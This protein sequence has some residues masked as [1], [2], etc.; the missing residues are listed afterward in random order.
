MVSVTPFGQDGP[1]A[2][3]AASDLTLYAA[4]GGLILTG[5]PDRPPLRVSVP[6]IWTHA[7]TTAAAGA[8]LALH[9][10]AASG[11]GQHVDVA[12][13]EVATL[14]S[15]GQNLAAPARATLAARA[16]GGVN[17]GGLQIRMVWDAK[18]GHVSITHVFGT[19]FG[20]FTRRLMEWVHEEG[21]CDEATRD[22][23]W[24]GYGVALGTGA[25]SAEEYARVQAC[26]NAFTSSKTKAELLAGA[27][28]RRV[29]VAP[30]AD[31]GDVAAQPAVRR[32]GLLAGGRR[33]GARA[34]GPGRGHLGPPV[35]DAAAAARAATGRRRAHRRASPPSRH[36]PDRRAAALPASDDVPAAAAEARAAPLA[37]LKVLDFCWI[38]A[39]PLVTRALADFGATVVRAR[40]VGPPGRRPAGLAPFLDDDAGPETSLVFANANAGKLGITVDLE[41]AEAAPVAARPAWPGRTSSSS[42][43]APGP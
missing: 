3:W 18:D 25:E 2:G 41:R 9:E 6:Q 33:S 14:L 10:R 20:P 39:G 21:F 30:V 1:K 8:V 15:G 22:K 28:E 34:P 4:S 26:I 32:A 24:I 40:V 13:Q 31:V 7:A 35:G 16:G 27:L 38:F 42:R 43:S 36:G 12:A 23:D 5:D 19:F 29:L 37:G 17:F 11:R